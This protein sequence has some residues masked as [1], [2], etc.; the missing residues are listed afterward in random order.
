M[1]GMT[2]VTA[3]PALTGETTQELVLPM[4]EFDRHL[5]RAHAQ[6]ASKD[7]EFSVG[8]YDYLDES[9]DGIYIDS[10]TVRSRR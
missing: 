2:L 9:M 6:C 4:R 7:P 8:F 1:A 3:L 10:S 5:D